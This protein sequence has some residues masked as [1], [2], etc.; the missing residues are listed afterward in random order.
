MEQKIT[1]K[2]KNTGSY[3]QDGNDPMADKLSSFFISCDSQ[4]GQGWKDHLFKD[5][6]TL[7][8]A[9]LF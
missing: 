6:T 4:R 2:Q 9:L 3:S 7:T 5:N 8:L 1:N